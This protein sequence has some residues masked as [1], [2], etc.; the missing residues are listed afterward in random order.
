LRGYPGRVSWFDGR[1]V[2]LPLAGETVER[3]RRAGEDSL[4]ARSQA[5]QVRLEGQELR[6][7]ARQMRSERRM[8]RQGIAGL[9]GGANAVDRP[10][11]S[12]VGP[13]GLAA[14]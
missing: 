7:R 9:A 13:T 4:F 6:A 1:G 12:S 5:V 10:D 3:A 2:S 11:D 14:L 8:L